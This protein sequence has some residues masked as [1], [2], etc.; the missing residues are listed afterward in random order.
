MAYA[1][2]TFCLQFT[3]KKEVVEEEK[4]MEV[5]KNNGVITPGKGD[6][7]RVKI[8]AVFNMCNTRMEVRDLVLSVN[9]VTL[10]CKFYFLFFFYCPTSFISIEQDK[11]LT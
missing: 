4:E 9:A 2:P 1:V 5:K 10:G 11:S 7:T 6:I 8:S 3:V